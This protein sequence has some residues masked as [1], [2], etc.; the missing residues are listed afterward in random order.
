MA[1]ALALALLAVPG[2][3]LRVGFRILDLKE[4]DRTLTVAL[5]YPTEAEPAEYLYGGGPSRGKV[6]L[7]APPRRGNGPYPFLAFSHGYGG[8]G[9][10]SVF[11]CE[12]LAARGWIVAAPDHED[13]DKAVRIRTGAQK[14]DGVAYRRRA[15]AL[16]ASGRDFDRKAHAYRL[17]DLALVL[18][19][20]MES[21]EFNALVDWNRVAA[22]GHSLGG[23]T[24]LGIAGAIEGRRDE[25]V[26]A[27]L[28]FSPGVFMYSK[29]EFAAV[30]V[31]TM[32]FLGEREL[33]EERQGTT[34][35]DLAAAAF[36]AFP[37]PR[38]Y[39]EVRG[40]SHF[41]F[42]NRSSEAAGAGLLSGTEDR[43]DVIRK[44]AIAFL[45]KHV[46]WRDDGGV[47]ERD[48][49]RL[50]RYRRE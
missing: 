39:L 48:D 50:S 37:S 23:F 32:F 45:E 20:L 49:P 4:R 18:D 30:K 35:S 17:D 38:Y 5:W 14:I 34:K 10:G 40:A 8:G 13:R 19:R 47:L 9:I 25:R 42:N 33:G 7:D 29:E 36:G 26:K 41:S 11:L 24:A 2:E 22:G 31:P 15:R 3:D 46:A 44:Y 12:A 27:V 43:F 21:D 1:A 6:S 16:A 28:L